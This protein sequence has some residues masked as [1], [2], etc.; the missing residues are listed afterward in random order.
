MTNTLVALQHYN[1]RL[2][3]VSE[4]IE[5]GA[6]EN[7]YLYVPELDGRVPMRYP[8]SWEARTIIQMSRQTQTEGSLGYGSDWCGRNEYR[9]ERVA[10]SPEKRTESTLP[11]ECLGDAHTFEYLFL[12]ARSV[13]TGPPLKSTVEEYLKKRKVPYTLLRILTEKIRER[14]RQVWVE[15][16]RQKELGRLMGEIVPLAAE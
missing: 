6:F 10:L 3:R 7:G 12:P 4:L 5:L 1:G 11:P 15:Y 2:Y 16:S 9:C 8:R 13:R 14:D